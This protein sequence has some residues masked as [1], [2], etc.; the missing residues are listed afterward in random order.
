M[1]TLT[2]DADHITITDRSVVIVMDGGPDQD[3]C[4]TPRRP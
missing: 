3:G 4:T 2:V 1:S